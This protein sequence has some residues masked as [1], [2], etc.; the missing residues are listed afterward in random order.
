MPSGH[1]PGSMVND[2]SKAFARRVSNGKAGTE[3]PPSM[4]EI[5]GWVTPAH[6]ASSDLY[7]PCA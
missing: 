7:A 3:S 4:R 5:R 2:A 6:R 1:R